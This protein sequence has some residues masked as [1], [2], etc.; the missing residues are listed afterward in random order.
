MD[1]I[2]YSRETHTQLVDGKECMIAA[3]QVWRMRDHDAF[4]DC[5]VLGLGQLKPESTM[6][7]KVARPYCYAS[8]VGTTGPVPLTGVEVFSVSFEQIIKNWKC[9]RSTPDFKY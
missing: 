3:G 4:N 2:R 9:V 5:T 1:E 6:W 8:C 7:V